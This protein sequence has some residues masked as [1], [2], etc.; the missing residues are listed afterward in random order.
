M[1]ENNLLSFLKDEE[2]EYLKDL[3]KKLNCIS[4]ELPNKI[5]VLT[6]QKKALESALESVQIQLDHLRKLFLERIVSTDT[7]TYRRAEGG[8]FSRVSNT[9]FTSKSDKQK[10]AFA[11]KMNREDL[12]YV[13][14]A[15]FN[16]LCNEAVGKGVELPQGIRKINYFTLTLRG[17]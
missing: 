13:K 2:I 16:K 9:S 3:S 17:V 5:A 15:D 14:S 8:T 6:G 7:Q 1:A 10:V 11:K 4:P 12:L